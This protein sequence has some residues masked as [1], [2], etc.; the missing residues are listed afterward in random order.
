[1]AERLKQNSI[2]EAG[3]NPFNAPIPGESLTT[4]PD[5]P[6]AWERPPEHADDD[7]AMEEIYLLLTEQDKLKEAVLGSIYSFKSSKVEK[8]IKEI[9][10]NLIKLGPEITSEELMELLS[11]QV[12]LE[13]IKKAISVQLGRIIIH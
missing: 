12:A 5:N 3:V 9:Q 1:M 10:K 2:E 8:R 4:S 6:K 13:Q 11:E 7:D